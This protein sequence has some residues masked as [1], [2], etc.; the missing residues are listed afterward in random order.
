MKLK[1]S[2]CLVLMFAA[3]SAVYA[4][5]AITPLPSPLAIARMKYK[6]AY[7]KLTY[8]Q[9]HKRGRAIFGN[10]VPFGQVWRL[11]ANEASEITLTRDM[12]VNGQNLKA[13]TYS[14]F[15]IPEKDKWT[16]IINSETGLWG[17][18][19]YNEKLDIMRF[20]VPTKSTGK[21]V[22]EAFQMKFDQKNELANLIINWD[23]VQVIIPF[24]FIN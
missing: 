18:Y 19:N 7:V 17:A 9:P 22:Y 24:K 2:L 11:G 12:Q 5:E 1:Q 6:D 23:D 21:L 16:I 20:D 15:T 14:I 10:L 8:A 13:G 3:A 4:Q